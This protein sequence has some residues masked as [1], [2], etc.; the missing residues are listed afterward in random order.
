MTEGREQGAVL[1]GGL[2]ER[3]VRRAL[4]AAADGP[5]GQRVRNAVETALDIVEADPRA[6]REAL[7]DLRAD[8]AKL[9]QLEDGVGMSPERATL[10]VGAVIQLSIAELGSANPDL[11]SRREELVRWL[12]GDW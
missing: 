5:R 6:A 11:R 7:C 3:L 4:E 12:E 8:P 2:D 1:E 10:A 9:Q